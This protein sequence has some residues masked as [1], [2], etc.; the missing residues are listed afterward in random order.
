MKFGEYELK[1]L[2]HPIGG[3]MYKIFFPN[4]YG[5]S[6]VKFGLGG[7]ASSPGGG[8]YGQ[9]QGL[10]ELAVLSGNEKNWSLTYST[11]ITDD[12]IGYLSTDEVS[13]TIDKIK[14]LPQAV[15]TE[16][17]AKS[18]FIKGKGLFK[19]RDELVVCGDCVIGY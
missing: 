9:S 8:S 4:G 3:E 15:K 6:I 7:M 16:V 1:D 19:P 17:R 18:V 12:V 2:V 14:E 5:A 10:Y 11:P 13:E